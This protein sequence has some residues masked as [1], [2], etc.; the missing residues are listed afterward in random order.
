MQDLTSLDVYYKS[1]IIVNEMLLDRNFKEKSKD[2]K[3]KILIFENNNNNKTYVK[4]IYEKKTFTLN[5]IQKVYKENNIDKFNDIVIFIICFLDYNTNIYSKYLNYENNNLQIF[6]IK[7]LLYNI[8]KNKYVPKHILLN[9]NEKETL[10]NQYNI[11]NLASIYIDDPICKYYFAKENDILKI[12]RNSNNSKEEIY[13][14]KCKK[15]INI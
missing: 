2:D 1:N 14:R 4:Y 5:N 9:P 12:I 8:T 15:K 13:Y 11:D 10:L 3:N 6:H 7:N